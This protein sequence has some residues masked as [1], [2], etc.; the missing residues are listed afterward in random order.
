MATAFTVGEMA[1]SLASSPFA[2]LPLFRGGSGGK[3][4]ILMLH[5]VEGLPG[6][7]PAGSSGIYAGG[8]Q[9]ARDAVA[10]VDTR[11]TQTPTF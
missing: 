6:A 11:D 10:Q 5:D 8:L 3:D 9:S 7:V 1:A 2:D 4:Q